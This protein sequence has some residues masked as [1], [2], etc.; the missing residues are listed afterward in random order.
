MKMRG[1]TAALAL[2]LII[3]L[4]A[5]TACGGPAEPAGQ[6][7]ADGAEEATSSYGSDPIDITMLQGNPSGVWFMLSNGLSECLN[8]SYPGSLIQ[9]TPGSVTTNVAR[10]VNGEAEFVLTHNNGVLMALRGEQM[11]DTPHPEVRTVAAFYPSPSQLVLRDDLGIRSL[12]EIIEN[13]VKVRLTIGTSNG[14]ME[15]SFLRLLEQSGVTREEMEG[16]G[17]ELLNKTQE[18]TSQMFSDG[19]I[20]GYYLAASSPSPTIMENA[21]SKDMVFVGFSP[22]TIEAVCE[23]YGYEPFTIPAGTYSFQNE[24]YVTY[25]DYSILATVEDVPA[26]Y[27]YKLTRSIHENL[28]YVTL[29]HAAL[30]DLDGEAMVSKLKAPLHPGAEQYYREAGLID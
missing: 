27:V 19:A 22:E 4:L 1:K 9:I 16:W 28:D 30:K 11:F 12:E 20:D 29:I 3:L 13:K 23:S 17:C 25:T 7:S 26:E 10:L 8:K 15:E 18:E 2:L 21:T 5:A 14:T 6:E 24:D